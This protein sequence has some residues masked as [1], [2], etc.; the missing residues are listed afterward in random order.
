MRRWGRLSAIAAALAVIGWLSPVGGVPA[1]ALS[2]PLVSLSL[3]TA[4]VDNVAG[5][6]RFTFNGSIAVGASEF[7]GVASGTAASD[8][9][10]R[11]GEIVPFTLQ[12]SGLA[13]T[14]SGHWVVPYGTDVEG[15]VPVHSSV[16]AASLSCT[17]QL[18]AAPAA[19]TE[20][21]VVAIETQPLSWHY[22][23]LFA[24]GPSA[25]PVV[26]PVSLGTFDDLVYGDEG[27]CDVRY[28]FVGNISL[29]GHVFRG[30][31]Y[32]RAP[33]CGEVT[34]P[35]FTLTG[36]SPSG[37]LSATCVD[38]TDSNVA[39]TGLL[40]AISCSG[41]VGT[42]PAGTTTLYLLRVPNTEGNGYGCTTCFDSDG[43]GVF[44]GA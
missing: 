16:V 3:G 14:C 20:L 23:G 32:G 6:S 44:I 8:P 34:P 37:D 31:A 2:T 7:Q 11:P 35:Q 22:T 24:P 41:H 26:A 10:L 42:G 21:T 19:E 27:G 9:Y 30:D 15:L 1:H 36:T 39:S 13:G 5:A 18:G 12:G 40:S 43:H 17:L 25:A 33:A 38:T 28:D 29:G 4:T